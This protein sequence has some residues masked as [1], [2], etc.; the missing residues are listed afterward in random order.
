MRDAVVTATDFDV[1]VDV[2]PAVLP[3][4]DL[5]ALDR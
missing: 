4:L 3:L 2:D 1:V 5:V